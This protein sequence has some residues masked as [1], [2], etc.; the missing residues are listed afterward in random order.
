MKISIDIQHHIELVIYN[1]NSIYERLYGASQALSLDC[2]IEYFDEVLAEHLINAV[3][4]PLAR[5]F[6]T[7]IYSSTN[8]QAIALRFFE[9]HNEEVA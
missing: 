5:E 4:S 1:D 6:T 3:A 8:V 7:A 2:F 9:E